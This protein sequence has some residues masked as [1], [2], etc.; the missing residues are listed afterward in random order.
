MQVYE[1]YVNLARDAAS[2]GDRIAAESYQ[3]Y[4][5]HYYRIIND[6]TDPQRPAP[7]PAGSERP[8]GEPGEAEQSPA[9][10]GG[11][12][13][14]RGGRQPYPMDAEQPFVDGQ[15][16]AG[17]STPASPA[18]PEG[19][20]QAPEA[21]LLYNIGNC[22]YRLSEPGRAALYYRRALLADPEHPEARQNLEYLERTLGSITIVHASYQE[23][24]AKLHRDTY[25]NTLLSSLWALALCLLAIFAFSSWTARVLA[26]CGILGA[27]LV[28]FLAV[29]VLII[30]PDDAS[31]APATERGIVTSAVNIDAL[32]EASSA[33]R[34]VIEAPPGSLCRILAPRGSWTYV[35]FADRTRGWL[36]AD[37]VTPLVASP[38]GNSTI[39]HN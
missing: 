36:P 15:V 21:G 18:A 17:A 33:G 32:T 1:K 9:E 29:G 11:R 37:Q 26:G 2:S 14:Q 6:T 23:F 35:E 22:H 39:T 38:P 28:G 19:N 27:L 16:P 12:E 30:Y 7:Q 24:F 20:G 4:A 13:R 25:R 8:G 3:Q 10:R 5:E 31:F 34:K